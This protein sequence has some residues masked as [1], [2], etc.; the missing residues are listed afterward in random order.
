MTWHEYLPAGTSWTSLWTDYI[1]CSDCAAIRPTGGQC[2]ACGS[3]L[4]AAVIWCHRG[5]TLE[6]QVEHAF[7]RLFH[8]IRAA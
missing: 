3:A 4:A 2:A 1:L 5:W 7:R 8:L 6:G